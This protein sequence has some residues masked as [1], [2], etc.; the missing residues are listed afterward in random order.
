MVVERVAACP[1]DKANVRIGRVPTIEI[2]GLTRVKQR[3]GDPGDG[4]K[5]LHRVVALRQ[6]QPRHRPDRNADA[7]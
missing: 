6:R 1:V 7:A 5:V 4:D 3:I 2:V